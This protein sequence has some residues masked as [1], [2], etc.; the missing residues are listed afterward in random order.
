MPSAPSNALTSKMNPRSVLFTHFAGKQAVKTFCCTAVM[1]K[2]CWNSI[3]TCISSGS[4]LSAYSQTS[5]EKM[6]RTV[7]TFMNCRIWRPAGV[8]FSCSTRAWLSWRWWGGGRHET[9][10][11]LSAAEW[12]QTHSEGNLHHGPPFRWTEA[13][14]QCHF[15]P[16]LSHGGLPKGKHSAGEVQHH[17]Q[18]SNGW[19]D[20]GAH[21]QSCSVCLLR[22]D[23]LS[24]NTGMTLLKPWPTISAVATL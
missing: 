24:G 1:S 20:A 11:P 9:V 19:V 21:G 22:L 6:W 18:E 14:H 16:S 17:G 5:G 13:V 2:Y 4:K 12:Q 15:Q 23:K 3:L 10:C 7:V 8:W